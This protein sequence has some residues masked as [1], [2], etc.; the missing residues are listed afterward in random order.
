MHLWCSGLQGDLQR[1]L[2]PRGGLR[3]WMSHT[4]TVSPPSVQHR[5]NTAGI[6]DELFHGASIR[7]MFRK[8]F[9]ENKFL[10]FTAHV[11]PEALKMIDLT[12]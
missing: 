3:G 5:T 10:A 12:V 1:S 11:I 4:S 8:L 6:Y 7:I 9:Y 2:F